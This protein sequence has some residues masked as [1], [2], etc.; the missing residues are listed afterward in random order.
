MG[1]RG[2]RW[3]VLTVVVLYYAFVGY[4]DQARRWASAL[5]QAPGVS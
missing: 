4:A 2:S 5:L 3:F 1:R